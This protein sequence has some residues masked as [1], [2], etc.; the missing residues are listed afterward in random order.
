MKMAQFFPI[1]NEHFY[2]DVKVELDISNCVITADLKRATGIGKYNA[3]AKPLLVYLKSQ[4][5][6]INMYQL[7][8]VLSHLS[9]AYLDET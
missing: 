6:K 9:I 1:S 2:E 4:V 3:V 8:V 7:K 5:D